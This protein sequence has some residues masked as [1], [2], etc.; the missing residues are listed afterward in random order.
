MVKYDKKNKLFREFDQTVKEIMDF[1]GETEYDDSLE[2]EIEC[3]ISG[4][5]LDSIED[6]M[7]AENSSGCCTAEDVQFVPGK[8]IDIVDGRL[9]TNKHGRVDDSEDFPD[10]NGDSEMCITTGQLRRLGIV[11]RKEY[12]NADHIINPDRKRKIKKRCG[13]FDDCPSTLPTNK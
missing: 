12:K 10:G 13:N 4:A 1:H 8:T 9:S 6:E 3:E 7:S 11:D 5:S 2:E